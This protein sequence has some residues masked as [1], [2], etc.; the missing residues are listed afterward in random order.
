V[1]NVKQCLTVVV[2]LGLL[3]AGSQRAT[4]TVP[5]DLCTGN[6]CVV[7]S[8]KV[9]DSGSDLDFGSAALVIATNTD[10]TI[11]PG[12]PPTMTLRAASITLQPNAKITEAGGV[13][14]LIS[15][16][17][18]VTMQSA[19]I[20]RSMIDVQ[21]LTGGEVTIQSAANAVIGGRIDAD[22][23]GADAE[24]G[25][26]SI[27]AAGV[28]SNTELISVGATGTFSFGGELVI[29]GGTGVAVN[30]PID[31][32]AG[33]SDGGFLEITATTGDVLLNA[34]IN[35]SG[36]DPDGEGGPMDITATAGSIISTLPGEL[37]GRGGAGIDEDCGDGA[38]INLI[39]GLNVTVAGPVDARGGLHCFGGDISVTTGGNFIQQAT[40]SINSFGPGAFG[41]GGG[42]TAQ[43][44]GNATFQEVAVNSTGFGGL[45]DIVVLGSATFNSLLTA[46]STAI[47]DSIGGQISVQACN[48]TVSPTGDVDARGNFTFPGFGLVQ[49]RSGGPLLVQGRI[50]ASDRV[51]LRF[52]VTPP[53]VTGTVSPAPL[54]IQDPTLPDC[55]TLPFCGDGA[56]NGSDVCDDNNNVSCDGCR[57]DCTREDDVCG[58]GIPECGEQ[59]DD[60]N[61][62]DDDGC[63][64][65]CTFPGIEGVRIPGVLRASAGCLLE[66]DVKLANP[67][68]ERNGF[69]NARQDCVDG[70]PL[71][72]ADLTKDGNCEVEVRGCLRVV[73]PRIESCTA[74]PITE[75]KII[76]PK[77]GAG[78]DPFNLQ[79][80]VALRDALL[81]LGGTVK[82]G[83]ATIIQ[84]GPPIA[85]IDTCTAP[86]LVKSPHHAVLPDNRLIKVGATD[87]AGTIMGRN[88]FKLRCFR[89]T[90]VCGNGQLEVSESCEDGN[91]DSCDGC[92]SECKIEACGNGIVECA[93]A[94]D[95]GPLN[96]TP[97]SECT[98]TCTEAVPDLRIAG[99][100]PDAKDC[101]FQWSMKIDPADVQ[102]DRSGAPHIKQACTDNDPECDLDPLV[103][104]CRLRVWACVGEPDAPNGCAAATVTGATVKSPRPTSK[105][106]HEQQAR[107]A[108]VQAITDL[109]LPKGPSAVGEACRRFE[110]NVPAGKRLLSLKVQSIFGA[111]TKDTDSLKLRCVLP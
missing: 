24:G 111:G 51:E 110:V 1:V 46:A 72:D 20:T 83:D 50:R 34:L 14:T 6:P 88:I 67:D 103:G 70:D 8:D 17:G 91:T 82:V 102:L 30:G 31:I 77:P 33:G 3:V 107:S 97:D 93:E 71:C 75:V 101:P 9:V 80:A 36:G 63:Q 11:G 66:W 57:A 23:A 39:A 87:A 42:F 98:A 27:T 58:D 94:C 108:L 25:L 62:E 12:T 49:L 7:S 95:D 55:A 84:T 35:T 60:G 53:V 81:A 109:G 43:I 106:A 96:G 38:E 76:T 99:G 26:V 13:V 79:N 48:L 41:G 16:V 22:G 104:R 21:A 54:I 47:A 2:A 100:G 29:T 61:N 5:A 44:A 105:F 92:S 59:C 37:R 52:K 73:D 90:A 32:S 15:T 68:I 40:G 10:I 78:A 18:D 4:A 89:N 19:G 74:E 56:I 28:V 64:A 85:G 69:P 45:V 86:F 65:D